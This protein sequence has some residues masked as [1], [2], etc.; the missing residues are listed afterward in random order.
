MVSTSP[1][2]PS[3]LPVPLASRSPLGGAWAG[4]G[5]RVSGLSQTP[6]TSHMTPICAC[7]RHGAGRG[8]QRQYPVTALGSK[9]LKVRERRPISFRPASRPK[10]NPIRI[11]HPLKV[12]QAARAKAQLHRLHS[13]HEFNTTPL[14][15]VQTRHTG[16]R[17]VSRDRPGTW[18]PAP[19]RLRL[20]N[21]IALSALRA[22]PP[23]VA[24][25]PWPRVFSR[26]LQLCASDCACRFFHG[27]HRM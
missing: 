18:R 10:P 3:A 15:R 2:A 1:P 26:R 21:K 13:P 5:G 16:T 12:T 14:T 25:G 22:V 8:A 17:R 23:G 11:A 4:R 24:H 9:K 27:H 7:A 20:R 19:L 6:I